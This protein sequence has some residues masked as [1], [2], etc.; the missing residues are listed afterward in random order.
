VAGHA[1]AHAGSAPLP[2]VRPVL[3]LGLERLRH[4]GPQDLVLIDGKLVPDESHLHVIKGTRHNRA[5]I[6]FRYNTALLLAGDGRAVEALLYARAALD[7]YRQAGPGAE[8]RTA[9]AEQLIASLEQG[10]ETGAS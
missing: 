2:Y 3:I 9:I 8:D 10:S 6:F 4:R 1:P 5:G 7:N